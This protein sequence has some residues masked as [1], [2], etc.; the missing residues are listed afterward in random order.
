[1]TARH[2]DNLRSRHPRQRLLLAIA[3][4]LFVIA[5][6]IVLVVV[7]RR[8]SDGPASGSPDAVTDQLAHALGAHSRKQVVAVACPGTGR[9]VARQTRTVLADVS[10]ARRS[11]SAEVNGTVAVARIE[12]VV[13]ARTSASTAPP[14]SATVALQRADDSGWCVAAFAATLPAQ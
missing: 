8:G 13:S 14:V 7:W 4:A 9:A 10:S 11:G 6:V 5:A 2:T 3:A 12:L 1:M